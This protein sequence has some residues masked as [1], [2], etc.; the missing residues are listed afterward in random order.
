MPLVCLWIEYELFRTSVD[1]ATASLR[2]LTLPRFHFLHSSAFS[3]GRNKLNNSRFTRLNGY[4]LNENIK[5]FKCE[6]L[7]KSGNEV[8]RS[9]W[10]PITRF[11]RVNYPILSISIFVQGTIHCYQKKRVPIAPSSLFNSYMVRFLRKKEESHRLQY[12]S[13]RKASHTSNTGSIQ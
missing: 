10:S 6:T 4:F 2:N 3:C 1:P 7:G 13:L 11:K 8:L 5:W 12:H 9:S